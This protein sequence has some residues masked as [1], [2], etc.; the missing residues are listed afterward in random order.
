MENGNVQN[1]R[2][3]YSKVCMVIG[4][5]IVCADVV[6]T[7]GV[8]REYSGTSS[9]CR[10]SCAVYRKKEGNDFILKVWNT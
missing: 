9:Q 1:D 2:K 4:L 8:M 3:K 6:L 10:M 7:G 5:S